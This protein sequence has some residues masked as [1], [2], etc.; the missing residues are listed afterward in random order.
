MTEED[1]AR[2]AWYTQQASPPPVTVM[3]IPAGDDPLAWFA[4]CLAQ[5]VGETVYGIALGAPEDV[6][7]KNAIITAFTGNG[8]HSLA[9]ANFYMLCH[10]AIPLLIA[11]VRRLWA[12]QKEPQSD[13]P[14]PRA[15]RRQRHSH[16]DRCE[17]R[18]CLVSL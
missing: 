2:I 1:L 16:T 5:S 8:T 12:R 7:E 4:D 10:T 6:E 15:R 13:T 17:C 14:P 3:H 18:D 11:E 9:N